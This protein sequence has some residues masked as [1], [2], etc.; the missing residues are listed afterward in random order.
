M[1]GQPWTIVSGD[2]GLDRVHECRNNRC[3]ICDVPLIGKGLGKGRSGVRRPRGA[4]QV[5][6][7]RSRIAAQQAVRQEHV[8]EQR[9]E[10]LALMVRNPEEGG[11]RLAH[12][13]A[14]IDVAHA[15]AVLDGT[16]SLDLNALE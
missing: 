16:G 13:H 10:V 2:Q 1:C 14:G 7:P 9:P 15:Q 11:M 8:R 4:G 12:T 6:I 3:I 5:G